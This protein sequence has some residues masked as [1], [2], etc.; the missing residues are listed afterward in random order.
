MRPSA[1]SST[2]PGPSSRGSAGEAAA[3]TGSSSI[4]PRTGTARRDR[5]WRLDTDLDPLLDDCRAILAPDG[6]LLLTAHTEHVGEDQ[7]AGRLGL[8]LRRAAGDI[9]TGDLRLDATSGASLG[10]GVF[11]RWDGAR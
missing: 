7:L 6:F 8:A 5:P 2:T 9:E 1:G 4:H 3:T 10:L 11:A